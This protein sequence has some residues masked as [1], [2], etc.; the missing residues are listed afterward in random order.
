MVK[1]TSDG[2]LDGLADL[3][4][5]SFPSIGPG[6]RLLLLPG[7]LRL[8]CALDVLDVNVIS[9]GGAASAYARNTALV[10]LKPTNMAIRFIAMRS[11]WVA[12]SDTLILLFELVLLSF[13]FRCRT[14]C[15]KLW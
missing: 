7:V 4:E 8:R 1:S 14:R 11:G 15:E 12:R 3:C 9:G 13:G 5:A 2:S 10:L 6:P